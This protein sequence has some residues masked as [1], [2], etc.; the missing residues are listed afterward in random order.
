[1]IGI[2]VRTFRVYANV[3]YICSAFIWPDLSDREVDL[4]WNR[5]LRRL[6]PENMSHMPGLPGLIRL[7]N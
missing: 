7:G 1:M 2:N 4:V 5:K 3:S 6:H